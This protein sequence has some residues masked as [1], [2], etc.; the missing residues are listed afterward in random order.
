MAQPVKD[1][2]GIALEVGN[3]VKTLQDIVID[4]KGKIPSDTVLRIEAFGLSTNHI[5]VFYQEIKWYID[6]ALV[7][8]V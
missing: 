8:K 4:R 7:K 5:D 3:K 1:S 2:T 6:A